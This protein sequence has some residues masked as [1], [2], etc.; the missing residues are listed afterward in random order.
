MSII[1]DNP[2]HEE[3][4]LTFEVFAGHLFSLSLSL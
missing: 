1:T 4:S 3:K 2:I